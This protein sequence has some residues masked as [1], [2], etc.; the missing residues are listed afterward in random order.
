MHNLQFSKILLVTSAAQT[1][2]QHT[3]NK[4]RFYAT[5][6]VATVVVPDVSEWIGFRS[7]A[8]KLDRV[9]MPQAVWHRLWHRAGLDGLGFEVLRLNWIGFRCHKLCGIGCD[10][11]SG[12][13]V[14]T[15]SGL[16]FEVSSPSGLGFEVLNLSGLGF[17]V[18]GLDWLGFE[19]LDLGGL[20]FEVSTLRWIG[21]RSFRWGWIGFRSFECRWIGFRSFAR[22]RPRLPRALFREFGAGLKK[23]P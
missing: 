20:V 21:F 1:L 6:F 12:F 2:M 7:F 11:R 10:T 19:V 8:S 22:Q 3:S 13:E 17:E 16:G 23:H 4:A 9:S 14:S 5:S 18:L 15:P